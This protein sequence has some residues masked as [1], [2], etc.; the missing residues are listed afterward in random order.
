MRLLSVGSLLF[1]AALWTYHLATGGGLLST[2]GL[3]LGSLALLCAVAS[4]L[5][6]GDRYRIDDEG[7]FYANPVL[8]RLGVH[9]ER[10]AAWRE[11][12]S[13]RIPRSLA[14]GVR[15]EVGGA[16]FLH[17]VSGRRFVIDSV[18]EFAEMRR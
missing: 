12:A 3:I 8:A 18:E 1:F 2:G 4:L 5:N 17:L 6:L 10:G 15:E 13:V 9:L 16:L 11:V 14:R 7:I